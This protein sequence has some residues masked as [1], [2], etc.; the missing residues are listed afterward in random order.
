MDV[1]I[2]LT[3]TGWRTYERLTFLLKLAKTSS[4]LCVVC[5]QQVKLVSVVLEIFPFD[6]WKNV[7][8]TAPAQLNLLPLFHLI[9]LGIE[10]QYNYSKYIS[11]VFDSCP[12]ALSICNVNIVKRKGWYFLF[13]TILIFVF[14][15]EKSYNFYFQVVFFQV[16]F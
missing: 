8:R 13:I 15:K 10:H 2:Q 16:F 4:L 9:W 3:F 12:V 7:K 1:V 5:C 11:N 14:Q 6:R